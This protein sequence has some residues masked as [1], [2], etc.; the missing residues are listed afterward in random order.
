MWRFRREK[1]KS[2]SVGDTYPEVALNAEAREALAAWLTE[3]RPRFPT[4]DEPALVLNPAGRRV[5]IRSIDLAL[6]PLG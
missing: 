3:R 4:S 5:S 6:A 2:S 1:G